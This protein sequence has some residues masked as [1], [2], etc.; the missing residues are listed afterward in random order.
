VAAGVV[1]PA[2][3][4]LIKHTSVARYL[5]LLQLLLLLLLL[6]RIDSSSQE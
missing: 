1:Q 3:R 6:L 5:H 4:C 2:Y